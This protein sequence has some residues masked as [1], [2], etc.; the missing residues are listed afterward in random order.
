MV[1]ISDSDVFIGFDAEF[2]EQV[3]DDS[4]SGSE[5]SSLAVGVKDT[6]SSSESWSIRVIA[7]DTLSSA[8]LQ[9]VLDS[10][11]NRQDID[12]VSGSETYSIVATLMAQVGVVTGLESQDVLPTVHA[13][14][15]DST[16]GAESTIGII[17]VSDWSDP[18]D[19]II[20]EPPVVTVAVKGPANIY[21]ADYGAP[22]PDDG[23]V[24]NS[25]S[26][27]FWLALG[28]TLGG[29]TV[30]V[31]QNYKEPDFAGQVT[32][33]PTRR[34]QTRSIEASTQLAEPNLNT[35]VFAMH[36]GTVDDSSGSVTTYEPYP[37]TKATVLDYKAVIID[38]WSPEFHPDGSPKRRRIIMRKCLSTQGTTFEYSKT[39]QTACAI[40]WSAHY[41][42][43][44]TAVVKIVDEV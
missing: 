42:D 29:V 31:T 44:T 5:T 25:P 24:A 36:G 23:Q 6:A 3:L 30:K 37:L 8:D 7:S 18:A 19:G 21:L 32:T 40:T 1:A 28:G 33:R 11:V 4:S 38:G 2:V 17:S 34:M 16:S 41:V 39:K 27:D 9:D 20:P 10:G 15:S 26:P 14:G 43:G 22:E 12:L 13:S 35:L